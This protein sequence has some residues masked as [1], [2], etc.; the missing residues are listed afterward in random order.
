MTMSVDTH[1][2]TMS[3]DTIEETDEVAMNSENDVSA[4]F[5]SLHTV[6]RKSFISRLNRNMSDCKITILCICIIIAELIC[7]LPLVGY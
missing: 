6:T 2:Y 3:F 4:Y 7:W 5:Q 1:A